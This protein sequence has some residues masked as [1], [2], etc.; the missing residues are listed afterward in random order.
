MHGSPACV[1]SFGVSIIYTL[2]L[3]SVSFDTDEGLQP[4]RHRIHT[5]MEIM[6]SDSASL[7]PLRSSD[8]DDLVAGIN[9]WQVTRWLAGVPHP[10]RL[11]HAQAYLARPEH[12]TWEIGMSDPDARLALAVCIDDRLVG[13]IS[14]VP[15]ARRPGCRE[16]G[17]WLARPA[18]GRRIMRGAVQA[19]I[20]AVAARV[21]RTAFVASANHD[22]QRSVRL[23]RSLGFEADGRD[24]IFSMPL[25]RHVAVNCFY[26][27]HRRVCGD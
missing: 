18:W 9:D 24:E 7:R 21:P 3:A 2:P 13:G 23:I 6:I 19:L 26:L 4:P 22:N 10:Y 17:F 14:L 25:Q 5:H 16:F 1:H 11:D 12:A 8:R 15:A 27:P 20:D